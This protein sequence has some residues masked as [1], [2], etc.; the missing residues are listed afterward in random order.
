M[1]LKKG[2][3]IKIALDNSYSIFERLMHKNL[4]PF[5]IIEARIRKIEKH[6]LSMGS[7]YDLISLERAD[8]FVY[9]G[10]YSTHELREKMQKA[11]P[12]FF[13]K[14]VETINI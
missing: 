12:D 5:T 2:D 14:E 7:F 6:Q 11:N 9:C 3:I 1:Q 13:S 4:P 8:S 10:C